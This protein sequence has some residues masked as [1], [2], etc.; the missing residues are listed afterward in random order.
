MTLT[1]FVIKLF[2]FQKMNI[3]CEIKETLTLLTFRYN[4]EK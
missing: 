4:K 2:F 3:V 1:K